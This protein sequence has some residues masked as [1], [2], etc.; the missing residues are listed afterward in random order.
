MASARCRL[1]RLILLLDTGSTPSV[2]LTAARQLA[3]LA[4]T[5]VGHPSSNAHGHADVKSEHSNADAP[6][7][8]WR[9][10][11]GEWNEVIALV[12]RVSDCPAGH[13]DDACSCILMPARADPPAPRI[14]LVRHPPGRSVCAEPHLARGRHLGPDRR[15]A[16][17]RGRCARHHPAGRGPALARRV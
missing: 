17:D 9:G 14:A 11:D 8:I 16:V 2:R 4:A 10:V 13:H 3:S 5:R 6:E 12:S 1:D 7:A 15:L